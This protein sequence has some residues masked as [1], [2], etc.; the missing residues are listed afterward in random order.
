MKHL[1]KFNENIDSDAKKE[2]KQVGFLDSDLLSTMLI[3]GN[4][5]NLY[6]FN[7]GTYGKIDKYFYE[8]KNEDD[9]SDIEDWL[10]DI[11]RDYDYD[12]SP[13]VININLTNKSVVGDLEV[14]KKYPTAEIGDNVIEINFE[15]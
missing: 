5:G 8:L 15:F 4:K 10:S 12:V 14:L 2:I 11:L 3:A 9:F 6:L 7:W 1:K 13:N